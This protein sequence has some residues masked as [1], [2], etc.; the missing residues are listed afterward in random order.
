MADPFSLAL[1]G[2]LS[3]IILFFAL[4]FAASL[5]R[6]DLAVPEAVGKAMALYLMLAIGFKGGAELNK[7]GIDWT[8]AG[9]LGAGIVLSFVIPLVAYAILRAFTGLRQADA[10]AVAAHYGSISV[11]TFVAATEF[12]SLM[13]L[14]FDGV[15][16]AVMAVMETPAIVSGIWLARRGSAAAGARRRVA[17]D[18]DLLRE[19][20]LNGS[21]VLLIG[22]FVIG[23]ITGPRGLETIAPFVVAPFKGVLCLFLLDM[24]LVAAARLRA[25]RELSLRLVAFGFVMPLLG[26]AFGFA[27][28]LLLG[29]GTAEMALLAVLCGSASYIAVP[30]SMRLAVPE[31]SPG[32]Y[33]TLALAITFP[34][35][36]TLGIPLYFALAGLLS[37][38]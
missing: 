12:L 34:F 26:A 5:L 6:S 10:A 37:G 31:A 1:D 22:A 32:I 28:G 11:V 16:V 14:S 35:N 4:G 19:I 21:V 13:D 27:A 23:W 2:L 7:Q 18:R 3:P 30:A 9:L 36:L 17:L 8:T 33:L 38:S 29:L 20:F 15:M 24:G 25:A